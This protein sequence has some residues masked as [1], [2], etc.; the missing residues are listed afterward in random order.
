[1]KR[2]LLYGLLFC[3]VFSRV[4]ASDLMDIYLHALDNDPI[5]KAAYDQYM[6][7]S[8]AIPQARAA[9]LPQ[10]GMNAITGRN[11]LKALAG[12]FSTDDYY[13]SSYWQFTGS[14]ALFNYQAWAQVAQAK[15]S[16]KAAQATFNDAAQDL[17]LRTAKAYFD[18]LLAQD[19]L[20]FAEAKKRANKRQFDQATQR[21]Q[22]G[23]VAITSV[24]EAKAAYDQ[25]NATVINA[26]N[27][28]VNQNENLRKLTNHYYEGLA[29]LRNSKIPLDKPE[30]NDVHQWV[31]TGLKQNYKLFSAKYALEVAKEN[32]RALSAGNWPVFSIQGNASELR[33][34]VLEN[35][36]FVPKDQV[37]S[38]IA[39]AVNIPFFQGGLV[40]SKTRQAQANF[41][42]YSERLEQTYRDVIVNTRIAFNTIIDGIS[43]VLADQQTLISQRNSLQSTEAQFKAGTRTM[44]DVTNAQERL[45]EAQ[46]QLARDQYS[47]ILA[48]LQLKYLAGSLNANDLE[49]VNSWLATTRIN[50]LPPTKADCLK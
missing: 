19:S 36:V 15:A 21:F 20:S 32:V 12:G 40:Q 4:F 16:V 1:M 39:L 45:F 38:N 2:T 43:K 18:V 22:I 30:P 3:S 17:M 37:E 46:E 10:L 6:I 28:Q 41:Q 25:S 42:L 29:P 47:F 23:V 13:A 26:K 11:Y 34:D 31:D 24:Y 5:F 14:Q 33:N 48:M 44:V 27:N 35:S 9:L 8:E 7:T 50:G 49:L